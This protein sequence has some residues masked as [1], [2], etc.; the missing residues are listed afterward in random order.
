[1]ITVINNVELYTPEYKGKKAIVIAND[2]IEGVYDEIEIPRNFL[3][4]DVLDGKGMCAVPGF[5]DSHVHIMGAGGEDGFKSRT[6]EISL[7]EFIKAGTT[8]V[9]GCIGTDGISRDLRG[10]LAKAYSLEEEGIT[11]Y[12]YTGSYDI[13]VIT[14][15]ESV[16]SDIVLLHKVI[17]VGE[18]AISD[19]RSSQPTYEEFINVIANARVGGLLSNKAGIV[20]VHIGNSSRKLEYL[21]RMMEEGE[22]PLGQVLPTHVNR[23]NGLFKDAIRYAKNGGYVDLTTAS[24]PEHLEQDEVKA[25]NGLR[26]MIDEKVPLKNITFSSDG[27]GSLPLFDENKQIIGLT[28]CLP[29]SLYREFK[30]SVLQEHIPLEKVLQV[31]TSN[32]ADL[33]KLKSKGRIEK[34][35]DADI[36]LLEKDTLDIHTVIAKGKKLME[37][38]QVLVKGTFEKNVSDIVDK[39]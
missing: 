35:K 14:A 36:L 1:M 23:T 22:V 7:S 2:K 20:N 31:V 21:F 33:L 37:N 27:N 16:K 17:G 25:S 11:S 19:H 24:D 5:I 28:I 4:I 29:S 13:P 10:L 6:P 15:T 32:V 18:I 30:D 8:T 38:K 3:E 9:V 26:R 12:C 34:G 39:E